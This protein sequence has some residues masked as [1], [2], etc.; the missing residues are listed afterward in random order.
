VGTE[1]P[2]SPPVA[3]DLLTNAASLVHT[4]LIG[5]VT[6]ASA[7]AVVNPAGF[8]QM[9]PGQ[10]GVR[11]WPTLGEVAMGW[12]SDHLEV[13]A[14]VRNSDRAADQALQVLACVGNRAMVLDGSRFRIR[15]SVQ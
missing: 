14:S 8:A 15:G 13:G 11:I 1:L 2:G 9:L 10:G 12:Q 3:A 5:L 7:N 4:R 6:A